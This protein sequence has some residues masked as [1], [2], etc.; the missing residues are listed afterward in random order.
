MTAWVQADSEDLDFD[1]VKGEIGVLNKSLGGVGVKGNQLDAKKFRQLKAGIG[2]KDELA[3]F[4]D[5]VGQY[6]DT[7][8]TKSHKAATA[9]QQQAWRNLT[10][11]ITDKYTDFHDQ[12]RAGFC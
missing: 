6:T 11:G 5:L 3:K 4:K 12:S 9:V 1:A 2:T 10:E 8:D 7:S